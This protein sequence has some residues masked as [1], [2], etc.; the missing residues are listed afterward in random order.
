MSTADTNI[1]E[2]TGTVLVDF[3]GEPALLFDNDIPEMT[4]M[5]YDAGMEWSRGDTI[6][7]TDEQKNAI[8]VNKAASC[9]IR[10]TVDGFGETCFTVELLPDNRDSVSGGV[11][12]KCQC[13]ST[14]MHTYT[15]R[16]CLDCSYNGFSL[17]DEECEILDIDNKYVHY[18]DELLKR[19]Q[20]TLKRDVF[21]TEV[22]DHGECMIGQAHN[23]GCIR[24]VCA[25][26][27][28]DVTH[29]PLVVGAC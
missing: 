18:D 3:S 29:I 24:V 4:K 28:A 16:D 17:S 5:A 13:G 21:R 20:E 25:T 27:G 1:E 19:A 23:E 7:L 11:K 12:Q 2:Y 26:C 14:V 10:Y 22:E 9:K 8:G 15:A 6:A